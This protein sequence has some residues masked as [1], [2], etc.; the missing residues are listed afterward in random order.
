[1]KTEILNQEA[2]MLNA[3]NFDL[4]GNTTLGWLNLFYS[5]VESSTNGLDVYDLAK[6]L[7]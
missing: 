5:Q 7:N 4:V 2:K 3:R 6:Y 1:M